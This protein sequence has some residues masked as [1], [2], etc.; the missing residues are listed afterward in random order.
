MYENLSKWEMIMARYKEILREKL[1]K[2][3]HYYEEIDSTNTFAKKIEEW[4]HGL[5][6][7]A[8]T[9]TAGRGTYGRTFH[10]KAGS[11]IYM[12]IMIDTNLWHFKNEK[13][14]TI[15]TAVAVSEAVAGVTKI[16]PEVKWVNDLFIDGKKIGGI[17][18]EKDLGAN[19]LIVGIG[20][21]LSGKQQDFPDEIKNI[22]ASLELDQPI[23]EQ[24]AAIVVAI[25]EK[26]LEMGRLSNEA[27]VL[28][29]Y[30]EKL[31]IVGEEVDIE[32]DNGLFKAKVIDVD[33]EGRLVILRDGEMLS[34]SVGEVRVKV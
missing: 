21:N 30:K 11:G 9:Q 10:S 17:L 3:L 13:L 6:I 24:A 7:I 23:D 2:N 18:T 20:I 25:Y 5:V 22:A 15:Y 12:T 29:L 26:M 31:F 33:D 32:Y 1:G 27:T 4:H 34:L 19:K 8:G 16:S 14:A 28:N